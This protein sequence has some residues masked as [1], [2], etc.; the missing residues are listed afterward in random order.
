MPRNTPQNLI[1]GNAEQKEDNRFSAP[2]PEALYSTV[3]SGRYQ[4]GLIKWKSRVAFIYI[5][6]F[7]DFVA[8]LSPERKKEESVQCEY[9]Q[10]AYYYIE[11]IAKSTKKMASPQEFLITLGNWVPPS[12]WVANIRSKIP[13]IHIE[14]YIADRDS[15]EVP[16]NVPEE[17]WR[18]CTALLSWKWFP[19][20]KLVPNLKYVQ[21]FSAGSNHVSG[22]PLFE[23]PNIALCTANGVHPYVLGDSKENEGSHTK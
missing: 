5:Y 17:S 14:G 11:S 20:R 18:R 21:L 6:L 22:L 12:D 15:T 1:V 7:L 8:F 3:I 19:D 10:S 16:K 13:N 23:D 4:R 2:T 9:C